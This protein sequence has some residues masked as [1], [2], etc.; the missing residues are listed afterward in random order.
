[1]R[2]VRSTPKKPLALYLDLTSGNVE[3]GKFL[4]SCS[5]EYRTVML[6]SEDFKPKN[7]EVT[8]VLTR[9][10][11][12]SLE[13]SVKRKIYIRDFILP[14]QNKLAIFINNLKTF[15]NFFYFFKIHF[16]DLS[17]LCIS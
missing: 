2:S 8:S 5:Y 1:M 7:I 12:L 10:R 14:L 15:I 4:N 17:K 6:K 3:S 9:V 13:F 16:I 11:K